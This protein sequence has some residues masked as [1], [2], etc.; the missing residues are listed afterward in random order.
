ML[1]QPAKFKCYKEMREAKLVENLWVKVNPREPSADAGCSG[2]PAEKAGGYSLACRASGG[3]SRF[4]PEQ[5][6]WKF[7]HPGGGKVGKNLAKSTWE[8][9][10]HILIGILNYVR[11][12]S[13]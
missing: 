3:C 8:K 10:T 1:L 9:K 6:A 13:S 2:L 11:H 7:L 4:A 12:C 5:M